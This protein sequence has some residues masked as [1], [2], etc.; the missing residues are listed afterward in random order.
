MLK[1]KISAGI[2]ELEISDD[3]M[4]SLHTQAEHFLDRFGELPGFSIPKQSR[5]NATAKENYS[6]KG[7]ICDSESLSA[8]IASQ[9]GRH[10]ATWIAK[11]CPYVNASKAIAAM[12]KAGDL[13]EAETLYIRK[14]NNTGFMK[15][16]Y[17]PGDELP[18][19]WPDSEHELD[20][21]ILVKWLE[22]NQGYRPRFVEKNCGVPERFAKKALTRL[23]LS[24]IVEVRKDDKGLGR[25]H[26]V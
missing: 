1:L 5:K 20:D 11:Y 21:G 9:D 24:K 26:S 16:L 3:Y 14:N 15:A 18:S 2:Y 22:D 25:V 6:K 7:E 8:W 12:L 13:A 23:I 4:S 10:S 19:Q 17:L